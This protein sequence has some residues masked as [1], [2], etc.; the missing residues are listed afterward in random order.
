MQVESAFRDRN[1]QLRRGHE[2]QRSRRV[3]D[4]ADPRSPGFKLR[5]GPSDTWMSRVGTRRLEGWSAGHAE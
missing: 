1:R 2:Q 3:P 4:G 5:F